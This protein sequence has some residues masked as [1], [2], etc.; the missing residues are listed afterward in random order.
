MSVQSVAEEMTLLTG[1]MAGLTNCLPDVNSLADHIRARSIPECEETIRMLMDD[2][3]DINLGLFLNAC[4][5]NKQRLN[6]HLLAE[7][8]R[9]SEPVPDL[10][11]IYKYQDQSAIEPL[12]RVALSND[13]SAF[14]M[15]I[16]ALIASELA[17]KFDTLKEEVEH[18]LKKLINR[19]N[20]P[21]C[22]LFLFE[23]LSMVKPEIID[24]DPPDVKLAI[25][26]PISEN[27]PESR[28]HHRTGGSYTIRRAVP[29]I[30]RN[31]PCHCGSGKK[32]KKCCIE[33]D[34]QRLNDPSPYEGLTMSDV[35]NNPELVADT[36]VI[37]SMQP[38]ELKKLVP[39]NLNVDQVFSAYVRSEQYGMNDL[40][41]AMLLE[42][43]KRPGE[44]AFA[45]EHM[46]DLV[47]SCIDSSDL[48][49]AEAMMSE[50]SEDILGEDESVDFGLFLLKSKPFF[51]E[52]EKNC[53]NAFIDNDLFF[54]NPLIQLCY[55]FEQSAPSLS[56]AFGRAAIMGD[57]THSLDNHQL[58]K[59]IRNARLDLRL[60]DIEDPV[61]T[62]V[63]ERSLN[64]EDDLEHEIKLNEI[65]LKHLEAE[66]KL[67]EIE[68]KRAELDQK[69][70][71]LAKQVSTLK[72]EKT[73]RLQNHPPAVSKAKPQPSSPSASVVE[74]K[75]RIERLKEEVRDQ[76][77]K[78]KALKDEL[79]FEKKEKD[80]MNKA[81][82]PLKPLDEAPPLPKDQVPKS[83][84]IPE[85]SDKFRKACR[86][87]DAS[88]TAKA[89]RCITG[90]ALHDPEIYRHT[91]KIE[92]SSGL[93][94]I[95][96]EPDYRLMLR[97]HD[98]KLEVLDLINR[99]DLE[100]WLKQYGQPMV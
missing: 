87:L 100:R 11:F 88:I 26:K 81:K 80:R 99:R 85:Y 7:T 23:Y 3:D 21:Q 79:D 1:F 66:E 98:N 47:H 17:V 96:T 15:M 97:Y 64:R 71:Q 53:R 40:A 77:K 75:M 18:M 82:S 20:D 95:K 35:K 5:V 92:S 57:N 49:L 51:D 86:K 56:I 94:R 69:E 12:I 14:R 13:L 58:I 42:L 44:A 45:E 72:K 2:G 8:V 22:H 10:M 29:K 90:F 74:L 24:G 31:D 93:Y 83:L 16:A 70:K 6:P 27:L 91:K 55:H 4:A 65:K 52:L 73:T 78:R 41:F 28:T 39:E 46:V 36:S 50:I 60:S 19:Y 33:I 30:G 37:E 34:A 89:L 84:V 25:D 67:H 38:Y 59:S 9:V 43:K 61:E 63:Y 54:N 62:W 76:Q 68:Q 48:D 32:Y